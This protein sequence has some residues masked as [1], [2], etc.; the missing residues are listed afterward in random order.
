MT[1]IIP[2]LLCTDEVAMPYAVTKITHSLKGG[3][4]FYIQKRKTFCS[5]YGNLK[6]EI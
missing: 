1:K 4:I 6:N 5:L 2:S 3:K